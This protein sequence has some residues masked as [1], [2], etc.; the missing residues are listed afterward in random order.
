M[1]TD[2]N[3][4]ASILLR[5]IKAPPGAVN[6]LAGTDAAG[7]CIRVL[8]DPMYWHSISDLPNT[9]EGYRVV[10][11]RREMSTAFH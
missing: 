5:Q 8:I 7:A 4:A 2:L 3:T 10:V 11:E 1:T 6:T 9:F